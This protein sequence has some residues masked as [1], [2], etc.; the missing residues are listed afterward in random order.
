MITINITSVGVRHF[1]AFIPILGS[2][3]TRWGSVGIFCSSVSLSVYISICLSVCISVYLSVWPSASLFGHQSV[4]L[5][6]MCSA[7]GGRSWEKNIM[8]GSIICASACPVVRGPFAVF[9][10]YPIFL[11]LQRY[12]LLFLLLPVWGSSVTMHFSPNW[13][14]EDPIEVQ[15]ILCVY[16][17]V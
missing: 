2:E 9:N 6:I 7:C 16:L 4:R 15:Q 17:Y 1:Y 12:L 10:L 14:L 5:V 13:C 11:I 3:R 8:S